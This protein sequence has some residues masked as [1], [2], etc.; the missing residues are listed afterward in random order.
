M[1]SVTSAPST[2]GYEEQLKEAAGGVTNQ[3]LVQLL[4]QKRLVML[5]ELRDIEVALEALEQQPAFE[6]TMNRVMK[7]LQRRY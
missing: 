3:N 5:A 4:Q 7:I 6:P 2:L 1:N